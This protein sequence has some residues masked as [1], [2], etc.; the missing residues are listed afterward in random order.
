MR[1]ID[2]HSSAKVCVHLHGFQDELEQREPG[3]LC[4]QLE[5]GSSEAERKATVHSQCH[6]YNVK[7]ADA[8]S[9]RKQDLLGLGE[10]GTS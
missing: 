10:R 4:M 3:H 6:D 2:G 7:V 5:R 8:M 1:R 9:L